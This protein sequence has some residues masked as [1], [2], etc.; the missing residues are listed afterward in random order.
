MSTVIR[1]NQLG[2]KYHIA[3]VKQPRY[4]TIRDVVEQA[5]TR[6]VQRVGQIL[7]GQLDDARGL[8]QILWALQAVDFEVQQG[9]VVGIIGPNGAGKSTLLKILSRITAPTTGQIELYGRTGALLEVG[10]GFHYELT[11]R[12]NVYLN[13]AILGMRKAEIDRKFDEIVDFAGIEA[14]IDTPIKYYSSGMGLRLGFAVAAHL[15]PDILLVD[16]VLAVGD[17]AFQRKSLGKLNDIAHAGRTVLFVSHNLMAVQQLCQRAIYLDK[18]H[19]LAD[20]EVAPVITQYLNLD[21]DKLTEKAWDTLASAPGSDW[22]RLKRVA[23]QPTT[24][25]V[26]VYT[27]TPLRLEIDYWNLKNEAVLD[28]VVEFQNDQGITIFYTSTYQREQWEP[29][30]F[31]QGLV[32]SMCQIPG[33]LLNDGVYNLTVIFKGQLGLA[34]WVEKVL[35]FEVHDSPQYRGGWVG[36]WPGVVRP[37]LDWTTTFQ[38]GLPEHTKLP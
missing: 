10:T 26:R 28:I 33:N 15:E 16:E 11:G 18:G 20:G 7:R 12:E 5:F 19:I 24:D 21:T 38:E 35:Y 25:E 29:R 4:A 36:S 23:L 22:V 34:H 14:F 17:A 9:E 37:L 32:R 27:H 13:G 31:A 2:K 1:V 3:D 8:E 6:P 30:I